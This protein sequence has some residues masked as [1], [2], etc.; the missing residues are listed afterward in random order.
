MQALFKD[1]P[2]YLPGAFY[3]R[4][5]SV[6]RPDGTYLTFAAVWGL[7]VATCNLASPLLPH[8]WPD[9]DLPDQDELKTTYKRINEIKSKVVRKI[10]QQQASSKAYRKVCMRVCV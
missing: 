3:R 1:H 7:H 10:Q 8:H 9:D 6:I 2:P 4:D 5:G